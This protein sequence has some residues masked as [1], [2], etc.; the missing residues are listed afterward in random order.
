M[1]F[2]LSNFKRFYSWIITRCTQDFPRILIAASP[3]FLRS[4]S[5]WGLFHNSAFLACILFLFSLQGISNDYF[6]TWKLIPKFITTSNL[7]YI[8]TERFRW[9]HYLLNSI[10]RLVRNSNILIYCTFLFGY[11]YLFKYIISEEF[12]LRQLAYIIFLTNMKIVF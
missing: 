4:F 2:Q 9:S 6:W 3:P 8:F 7:N 1:T 11:T 12:K 5:V 10:L